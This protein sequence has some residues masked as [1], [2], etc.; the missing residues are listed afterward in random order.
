M[1]AHKKILIVTDLW[2]THPNGVATVVYHL[3]KELEKMGHAVD[4][5]E[6]SRF[7]TVPFPL[8]PEM[9]LPIFAMRGVRKKVESGRYDH[10]HIETEALL[11]LYARRACI[12]LHI[13]FTT[14]LHGQHHLYAK[15]WLG[16]L[17]E[18]IVRSFVAWFHA[19]SEATL[20]S[21]EPVKEQMLSI[22]LKHV[23]VRPLGVDESFFTRGTCPSVLEKP[24]FLFMGRVS[25]EKSIDEFL[26][27]DLPGTK[28][29]VGDG[30][31]RKKLEERFPEAKFVGSQTGQ[32]L[33]AWCSCADVMV[34]PSRTETFGLAMV[35]CLALGIP[36][37]AHDVTG[38]REIVEN[39]VNGFLDEDIA[40]AAKGCLTLSREACRESVRK[41]SWRSSAETFL[42]ILENTRRSGR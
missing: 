15:V 38:P 8:Y 23:Y 28:L 25:S 13:P 32:D 16:S 1:S 9:R 24:V 31:D 2:H 26:S 12:R 6:P 35:E 11:G 27:A 3:K 5:L 4:L 33:I 21:T 40:R 17:V 10:I 22:G 42:S 39:G 19:P 34:M 37:A 18:R 7:F 14:S 20:V 41:Y 29:V 30:P 36:V